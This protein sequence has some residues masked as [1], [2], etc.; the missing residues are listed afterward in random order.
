MASNVPARDA[1]DRDGA[2]HG[3]TGQRSLAGRLF[4]YA[5][6]GL[7]LTGIAITTVAGLSIIFFMAAGA[8]GSLSNPYLGIWELFALP[9]LFFLGLSLMPFGMWRR[10]RYL[11][12]TGV[13]AA[14]RARYPSL[15][16]ND[17]HLRRAG[18]AVLGLT[19]LN[20][21][22][23]GFSSFKVVEMS[24]S[25]DFCGTA[26][27][28]M[29]PEYT[30]YQ[31]TS[32][33]HVACVD[34]HIGPGTAFFLKAKVDGLRQV[35]KTA[36]DT[37][38]RPIP[39]PVHGMRPAAETCGQCH[40]QDQYYEERVRLIARFDD[41]EA[42]SA[43]YSAMVIEAGGGRRDLGRFGGIHWWHQGA[44]HR[45]RYLSDEKRETI[46]WVEL[47]TADGEVRTYL[48]DG[49]EAPSKTEIAQR[50]RVMDCLDCHNRPTHVFEVP[51]E[52]L[53]E[54]LESQPELRALPFFKR[55]ALA[56]IEDEYPSQAE[57]MQTIR[58]DLTAFY[59]ASYPEVL[60]ANVDLVNA[61]AD[62]AAGVY[63]RSVFPEMQTD[64]QTHANHIGHENFPGC[65]RCHDE[66]LTSTDGHYV[67]S[68][69]CELCHSFPVEAS[70]ERP[71]L[72]TMTSWEG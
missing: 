56:A 47:R 61:G 18:T 29:A 54:V 19:A 1:S 33:A 26:C 4:N 62:A 51:S 43:S 44:D 46:S 55:E 49:D 13:S 69:D 34:C 28:V 31:N 70:P 14:E 65:F 10:R 39:T 27:H 25:V 11:I 7:T 59:Q 35:W 36:T 50:A 72:A 66:E 60:S 67:I 15:D 17:P 58:T 20:A 16:F 22:I 30:T 42:N 71:E 24:S 57:G 21:L 52:A 45:I 40:W 38:A 64:W 41:D 32:H 12:K 68:L 6:N 3:P 9:A 23:L 37:Y 48:R 8:S 5:N 53:D 63:R 2:S